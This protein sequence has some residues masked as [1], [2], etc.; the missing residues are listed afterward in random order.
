R[1]GPEQ[2]LLLGWNG[3]TSPG[4]IASTPGLVASQGNSHAVT[5]DGDAPLLTCASTGAGKGRCVLIPT[6]LT[7]PGP[8][9]VMDIK[10]ELFQ[11]T[12][13]RRREMGQRV[14]VL[15]P[16]HLVTEKSD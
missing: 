2:Q 9:I 14:V 6:L 15:D 12:S 10:G 3:R 7:Y 11:V 1:G 13:R 16:S 4:T 8:V 5:Y